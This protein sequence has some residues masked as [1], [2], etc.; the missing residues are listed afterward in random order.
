[1]AR[2]SHWRNLLLWCRR[3]S[4][5]AYENSRNLKLSEDHTSLP[6]LHHEGYH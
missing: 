2:G 1:M 4:L 6:A 5:A 3:L